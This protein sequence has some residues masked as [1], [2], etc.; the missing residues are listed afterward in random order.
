MISGSIVKLWQKLPERVRSD[1]ELLIVIY[2]LRRAWSLS[3]SISLAVSLTV[4]VIRR[5][6]L[7]WS[8]LLFIL[9]HPP[10]QRACHDGLTVHTA[11]TTLYVSQSCQLGSPQRKTRASSS[12][13]F[14]LFHTLAGVSVMF[15]EWA[16]HCIGDWSWERGLSWLNLPVATVTDVLFNTRVGSSSG[17]TEYKLGSLS[18][19]GRMHCQCSNKVLHMQAHPFT[20]GFNG[21]SVLFFLFHT[22]F[23][24]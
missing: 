7:S 1:A 23:I 17:W 12:F 21:S 13:F 22:L 24:S 8:L 2:P 18:P 15:A 5:V 4:A 11:M 19:G 10:R 6:R 14:F 16:T 3:V 20:V 9:T